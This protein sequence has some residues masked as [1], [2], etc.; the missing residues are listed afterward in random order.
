MLRG[1]PAQQ[2][3]QAD[4]ISP[5]V[6][7]DVCCHGSWMHLQVSV[8]YLEVSLPLERGKER[9]SEVR[10][11]EIDLSAVRTPQE[12][13]EP[14]VGHV[15][16]VTLFSVIWFIS[17]EYYKCRHWPITGLCRDGQKVGSLDRDIAD[18]L[19]SAW[20]HSSIQAWAR[21]GESSIIQ[22]D[23]LISVRKLTG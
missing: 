1:G 22:T 5:F 11:R 21:T 8:R 14:C 19:S 18:S 7:A 10:E 17:C 15:L 2:L 12:C 4:S 13:L 6:I 3:I 23:Y 16:R 9:E 20:D